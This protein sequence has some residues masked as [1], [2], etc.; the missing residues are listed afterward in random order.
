MKLDTSHMR[1]LTAEDFKVLQAVES[2]TRNHELVPT[3]LIHNLG[4]LKL[5]TATQRLISDLAKLK[6]I[7]RLRNASYDGFRLMHTGYDYLALKSLLNTGSIYAVGSQIGVG[8]ESDIL[9]V[10]DSKGVQRV[11]KVHRLGRTSFKTIKNNRDYLKNRNESNWMF[12]SRLAAEKEYEFMTVLYDNGFIVPKPYGHSRHCVLMEWIEGTTMKH[13]RSHKNIK[14][15]Y[16][17]LMNFIVQLGNAGLIHCDFNEFNIIVLSPEAVQELGRD[18]V[19][20]DFPQCVSIDHADARDYFSRDVRGVRAFFAKKFRYAPKNDSMMLDRDGFG[21]GYRYAYPDFDRDVHRERSLD[22]EVKAS[23]YAKK[24]TGAKS[25][26]TGASN[27]NALEGALQ[28]MRLSDQ[29]SETSQEEDSSEGEYDLSELSDVESE[30]DIHLEAAQ[31]Q[32]NE[33]I[34]DALSSGAQK[35]KM[36]KLGNYILDE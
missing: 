4:G 13:L 25:D 33:R 20:I 23:G 9:S 26:L 17:D 34:I 28:D 22:V 11:L 36:D 5:P 7:A 24:V 18:F 1:Y 21:E 6:L 31:A 8:K 35:L 27:E 16:S 19:V 14:K 3:A 2:G 32:E 10:S 15:L 29:E 30:D 12:L